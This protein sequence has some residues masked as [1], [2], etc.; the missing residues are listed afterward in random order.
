M[1]QQKDQRLQQAMQSLANGKPQDAE[2]IFRQL[3]QEA[4]EL[5]GSFYG[6]GIIRLGA[7]DLN[8]SEKYFQNCLKFDPNQAN[9]L[10][11]LGTI[12]ERRGNVRE[13][14]EFYQRCLIA[15]PDHKSALGW[16]ARNVGLEAPP[17]IQPQSP[18][19]TKP[20]PPH[21][22]EPPYQPQPQ[23]QLPPTPPRRSDIY[24][25]LR[26]A[27]EPVERELSS[28]LDSIG[29]TMTNRVQR[30][31]ALIGGG[32]IF[33]LVVEGVLILATLSSNA[34]TRAPFALAA[35]GLAV[36]IVVNLIIKLWSAKTTRITCERDWL[37]MTAGILS[38]SSI[39]RH[40]WVLSAMGEVSTRQ[41][42]MNRITGN[43]SLLIDD[44]VIT[45]F[46]SPN[47]L[48]KLAKEFREM[49]MLKPGNREVLAAL[50]ELKQMRT[51]EKAA[52]NS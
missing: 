47:E 9:A 22:G 25:L 15:Q 7:G 31:S 39:N 36:L 5:G 29:S 33:L 42:L 20:Q 6:L 10:Y 50:G 37:N 1:E 32:T 27:P 45:G 26:S 38:K 48:K 11:Y 2:N 23:P 19:Q 41:S 35:F 16:F 18:Y 30:F 34:R 12:W 43:G 3:V 52:A 49:S 4:T 13:A 14:R 44:L 51:Q 24:G 46:F 8:A 17:R 40:L 28:Y 21:Q